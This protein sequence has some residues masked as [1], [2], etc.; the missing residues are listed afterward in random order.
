MPL[1]AFSVPP[2][3]QSAIDHISTPGEP[4]VPGNPIVPGN[5]VFDG[6]PQA[7]IIHEIFGF[8]D[9][10]TLSTAALDLHGPAFELP[11]GITSALDHLSALPNF[12]PGN[13]VVPGNPIFGAAPAAEIIDTL[14]HETTTVDVLG[15]A[16]LHPEWLIG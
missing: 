6:S 5:P 9:T 12:V 15:T 13:P 14:F 10:T 2:G 7:A 8:S 11:S 4:V 1:P 16:G 3:I